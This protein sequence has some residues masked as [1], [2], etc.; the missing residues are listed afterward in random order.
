MW[1]TPLGD[2]TL[3]GAEAKLVRAAIGVMT[4]TLHAEAEGL[5]D[6]WP[7]GIRVFDELSWQQR[8]ALLARVA[9]AL[10]KPEI[11]PPQLSAV[12]EATV[13]AIFAQI[14]LDVLYE[15]DNAQEADWAP[16]LDMRYWRR[17][18]AS[19]QEKPISDDGFYI[20]EQ[21]E[22]RDDWEILIETLEEGIL[23]DGDWDMPDLFLDEPPA[24]SRARRRRVGI[25]DDYFVVPAPDLADDEIPVVFR[26]LR[27]LTIETSE[28]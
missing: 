11:L 3:T 18:I 2:R 4:D 7:C 23:W 10:F 26:E 14:R 16:E 9:N 13:A 19:C 28:G 5:I 6:E 20:D 21:S 27:E 25:E 15:L 1:H 24:I 8:L 22:D 17:L 12:N